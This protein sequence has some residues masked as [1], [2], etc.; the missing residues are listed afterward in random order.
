VNRVF[1]WWGRED[2]GGRLERDEEPGRK[3]RHGAVRCELGV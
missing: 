1:V 3:E 2:R